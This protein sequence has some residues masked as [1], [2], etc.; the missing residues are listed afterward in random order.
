MSERHIGFNVARLRREPEE[1]KIS[2][3]WKKQNE[4]SHLLDYLLQPN[5]EKQGHP[6]EC[7]DRDTKVA[8]TVIQWL[9]S[10]VGQSFLE[11]LGYKKGESVQKKIYIWFVASEGIA[12]VMVV[13]E[14]VDQARSMVMEE[15]R[16][17]RKVVL[18]RRMIRDAPEVMDFS[19]VL[20]L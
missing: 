15:A 10:P 2:D 6:V 7:S 17:Q 5:P 12:S 14:N 3:A 16:R 18:M 8:A 4:V 13:A 20:F 19:D 11:E 1:K 9:G